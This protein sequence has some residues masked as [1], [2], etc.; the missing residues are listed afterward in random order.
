MRPIFMI[1]PVIICLSIAIATAVFAQVGVWVEKQEMPTARYLMAATVIDGNIYVIGGWN[2]DYLKTVEMY[3]PIRDAWLPKADISQKNLGV[4]AAAV[5][6]KIYAIG[7]WNGNIL[8]STVEEYDPATDKWTRRANMPTAKAL[9]SAAVVDGIIYVIGGAPGGAHTAV[10]EAYDPLADQWIRKADAPISGLC[11]SAVVEQKIYAMGW[12]ILVGANKLAPQSDV[13]EYDPTIDKWARKADMPTKRYAISVVAVNGRIY[14]VVGVSN[15]D[16]YRKASTVEIYDPNTDTWEKGIN[17]PD[18][19]GDHVSAVVN[20]RIYAIG[21]V[22]TWP[23]PVNGLPDSVLSTVEVF[24]TG[25]AVSSQ[26]RLATMWGS[27]K[28]GR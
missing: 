2:M 20:G 12:S 24:D 25:L 6:G 13:Y 21:G 28:R 27:I 4:A 22:D 11:S 7:G 8:F 9:V 3:D 15:Q 23:D 5:N 19:R 18:E 16:P 17:L 26:E 14:A 10:V 1:L